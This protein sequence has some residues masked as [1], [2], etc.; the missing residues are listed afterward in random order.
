MST[1]TK[2]FVLGMGILVTAYV[3]PPGIGVFVVTVAA[4][5]FVRAIL[6]D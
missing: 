6:C 3:L 2:W 4:A 1:D 5:A